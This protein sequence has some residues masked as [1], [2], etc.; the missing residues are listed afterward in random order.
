M[1]MNSGRMTF[2]NRRAGGG[3]TLI[4]LVMVIVILGILSA[5]A[6]PKFV[7][8]SGEAGKSAALGVAG[9]IA[10]GSAANFAAK[11]V[12][13]PSGQAISSPTSCNPAVVGLVLNPTGFPAGFTVDNGGGSDTCATTADTVTCTVTHTASGKTAPAT[14]FCAR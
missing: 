13:S 11:K 9:A 6:L 1:N 3:F 8:L 14:L 2:K 7:D 10:G 4:E 12:G 5:I